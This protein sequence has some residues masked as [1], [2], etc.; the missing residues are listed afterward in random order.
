MMAPMPDRLSDN[1]VHERLTAAREALGE[2]EADTVRGNTA[3]S[4]ARRALV[5]LTFGLVKAMDDESDK[6]DGV[7]PPGD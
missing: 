2:D 4:A 6:V 7:I 5:I 1:D 3:I